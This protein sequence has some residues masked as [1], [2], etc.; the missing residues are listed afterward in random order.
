MANSYGTPTGVLLTTAG[1][2]VFESPAVTDTMLLVTFNNVDTATRKLNAYIHTGA[3]PAVGP[4]RDALSAVP[5]DF[6]LAKETGLSTGPW[7]LPA[8]YKMTAFSDVDNKIN[9]LP[10]TIKTV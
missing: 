3:L 2:V 7:Y 6:S 10:S 1:V 5:K 8:G 9:A 4:A